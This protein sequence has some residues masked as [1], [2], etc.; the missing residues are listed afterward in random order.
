MNKELEDYLKYLGAT[1]EE[2][3]QTIVE[4]RNQMAEGKSVESILNAMDL[5]YD[6]VDLL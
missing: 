6:L 2:A 1:T 5:P 3:R 4:I